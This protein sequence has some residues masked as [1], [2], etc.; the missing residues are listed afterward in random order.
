[1]QPD[2]KK[3]AKQSQQ[4]GITFVAGGQGIYHREKIVLLIDLRIFSESLIYEFLN[5]QISKLEDDFESPRF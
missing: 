3:S 1:M 4:N 5:P 2:R